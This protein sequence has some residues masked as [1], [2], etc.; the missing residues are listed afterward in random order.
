MKDRNGKGLYKK[1]KHV[2]VKGD[3]KSARISRDIVDKQG[4]LKPELSGIVNEALKSFPVPM[5]PVIKDTAVPKVQ[6]EDNKSEVSNITE[7]L[8]NMLPSVGKQLYRAVGT[9]DKESSDLMKGVVEKW[10]NKARDVLKYKSSAK[11]L[12]RLVK[13]GKHLDNFANQAINETDKNGE[14]LKSAVKMFKRLQKPKQPKKQS[15]GMGGIGSMTGTPLDAI[16][17][18]ANHQDLIEK[19]LLQGAKNVSAGIKAGKSII[20]D[21]VDLGEDIYETG[22]DIVNE[23]GSWFD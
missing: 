3:G 4:K 8:V 21:V 19:S 16:T 18:A 23:I 22:K 2:A 5:M 20:K 7:G 6:L 13:Y 9:Y 1:G 15:L 14:S 12:G 11:N 10:G 17:F